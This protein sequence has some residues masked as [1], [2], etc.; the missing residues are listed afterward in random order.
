M[1][2]ITPEV[3]A[4]LDERERA[5]T[6]KLFLA[7]LL[8]YDFQKDVHQELF[9]C[10]IPFDTKKAW[11][12]QSSIKDRMI[13]WPRGHY[14][15]TSIVVEA[16]Q[17]VINFPNLRILLMQGSMATTQNLL[18]EIKAHFLGVA[19]RSRFRNVFPEF[20]A[21]SLGTV[22]QF[23]TPARTEMQLQQSTFTVA[24]PKKITT[25]Q[26]YDIGFFDD[27]VNAQ[28]YQSAKKLQKVKDEFR[29]FIPLIDPGGYRQVTGTR[30]AFGD[31]YEDIAR[32]NTNGQWTITIKD[33]Y[34]DDGQKIRFEARTL[35]DG[36]IIGFTR[37]GLLLIQREDPAMFSSQY[38]N[39]PST[40]NTQL[41]TDEKMLAAVIASDDAPALSPAVLFIDLASATGNAQ[42]DD[43]VIVAGKTDHLAKMYVVDAVGGQWTSAQ[44]ANQ[45]IAMALK[46]RPVKI[47]VE[48][49]GAASYFVDFLK[50]MCRDK[51]IVLPLD[52][53]KI[54][55]TK[56]AKLIRISSLE[57]HIRTKRLR[58]FAGLPCWEKMHQQFV[59]FPRARYGHDDYPDTVALMAQTFGSSYQPVVPLSAQ[60]HPLLAAME[61]QGRDVTRFVLG[62]E[63]D[64][65]DSMGSE[66]E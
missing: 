36:R 25:G 55:N 53:I 13:I 33:C 38:L 49:T 64:Q 14:K 15:S 30:Y 1:P 3:Q 44:F 2:E 18:R 66:F 10:Y 6:D 51:N 8:G 28:N 46:H 39:K 23:T 50:V 43:S 26:H 58:F 65:S 40:G 4:R 48:H 16:I 61:Q 63:V 35:P 17:A 29:S 34:S 9:D 27:L 11:R 54:N 7:T 62:K 57:G 56:D 41:F 45:I 32:Y 24:S 31:L 37:D 47:M 5:R 19:P 60:R 22:N 42:N 20:C 21:D 59:E 12:E 52:F